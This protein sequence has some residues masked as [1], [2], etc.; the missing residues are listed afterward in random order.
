MIVEIN[1]KNEEGGVI[2]A[3]L[4]GRLDAGNA[5]SLRSAFQDMWEDSSGKPNVVLDFTNVDYVSS[6]WLREL[7]ML[8][9]KIIAAQGSLSI[10]NVSGLA[11][12]V[13]DMTGFSR[14]L[15]IV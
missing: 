2:V 8:Q 10:R 4:S 1:I 14:I 9:K 5:A 12:E 6:A 11:L 7:L 3:E 13:F 15:K